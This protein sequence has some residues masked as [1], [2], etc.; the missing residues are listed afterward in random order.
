MQE[1]IVYLVANAKPSAKPSDKPKTEHS[2]TL[3]NNS[4][5]RSRRGMLF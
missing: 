2:A 1:K 5:Q 4:R 3:I